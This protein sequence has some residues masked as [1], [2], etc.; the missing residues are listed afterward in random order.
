MTNTYQNL[1]QEAR[2]ILQDTNTDPALQRFADSDLVNI[3]NRGLTELYRIRTDAYYD[4]WSDSAEDFL[5]PALN[6]N[7]L[8]D[9]NSYL[10]PFALPQMFYP[11]LVN[12]VV[13]MTEAQ[14]DEFTDD[15]RAAMFLTQFQKAVVS[16]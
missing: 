1:I 8:P 4:L 14:D 12:W 5:V 2:F 15:S 10:Q 16:L 3:L 6:T 13:G 9:P 7:A 11:P